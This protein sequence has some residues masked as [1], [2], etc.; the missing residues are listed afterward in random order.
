MT[1]SRRVLTIGLHPDVP[2]PLDAA[3]LRQRL[4]EVEV[5]LAEHGYG[6][7]SC[8]LMNAENDERL[9]ESAIRAKPYAC[10]C[11]GAGLRLV[12]QNT[13]LFERV[14]NAVHR[15][16]PGIKFCFNAALTDIVAAVQ[17]VLRE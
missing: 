15:S 2:G 17:R 14:V 5:A 13:E 4:S 3:E 6:M 9:V 1:T 7:D 11:I 10:V 8:F 16:A 12:P